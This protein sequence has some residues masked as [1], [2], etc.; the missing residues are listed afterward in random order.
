MKGY[1]EMRWR[2]QSIHQAK[3]NVRR[4]ECTPSRMYAKP[5]V[6]QAQCTPS[7]IVVRTCSLLV[8]NS[9]GER[10]FVR[11]CSL[12]AANSCEDCTALYAVNISFFSVSNSSIF[13]FRFWNQCLHLEGYQ[14][15]LHINQCLPI[16]TSY[17]SVFTNS[18]CI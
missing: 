8:T 1:S 14:F 2:Y 17:K 12:M 10:I 7:R 5:N 4:G 13:V 3:A 15:I 18:Y 6:H 16:H 11:T 9:W